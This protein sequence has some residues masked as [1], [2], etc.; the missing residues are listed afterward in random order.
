MDLAEPQL[1]TAPGKKGKTFTSGGQIK[2]WYPL[3]KMA[4]STYFSTS[5]LPIARHGDVDC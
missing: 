5:T 1:F 2:V 4:I 3:K